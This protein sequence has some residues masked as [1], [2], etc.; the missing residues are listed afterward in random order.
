MGSPWRR[1]VIASAVALLASGPV[2][3]GGEG[4]PDSAWVAAR[5]EAA[6]RIAL[7]GDWCRANAPKLAVRHYDTA[8][9]LDP[10]NPRALAGLRPPPAPPKGKAPGPPKPSAKPGGTPAPAPGIADLIAEHDR[11][12]REAA[13]GLAGVATARAGGGDAP[14]AAEAWRAVNSLDPAHEAAR[15]ALGLAR[16]EKG[17]LRLDGDGPAAARARFK[18]LA[19]AGKARVPERSPLDTPRTREV[20]DHEYSRS[21]DEGFQVK[22]YDAKVNS[23]EILEVLLGVEGLLQGLEIVPPREKKPERFTYIHV[24]SHEA[25]ILMIDGRT[26]RDEAWKREKRTYGGT[27]WDERTFL[28]HSAT[29]K[30]T[31]DDAAHIGSHYLLGRL[32]EVAPIPHWLNEGTAYVASLVVCGSA[33]SQCVEPKV[34]SYPTSL[35]F[36]GDWDEE[37]RRVILGGV[38]PSFEELLKAGVNDLTV[39]GLVKSA[40]LAAWLGTTSPRALTRMAGAAGHAPNPED[41]CMRVLGAPPEAVDRRWR[42]WALRP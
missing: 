39:P 7:F 41:L 23:R 37:A 12:Y 14:G 29:P 19:D 22:A 9:A 35:K 10:A 5:A 34:S 28:S 4:A 42:L 18:A 36:L 3:P 6:E 2:A 27:W 16:A 13:A 8:L 15:V 25:Y 40:S 24:D 20:G 38:E 30:R 11:A 21:E 26:D 33:D 31:L 1:A 17:W 32:N